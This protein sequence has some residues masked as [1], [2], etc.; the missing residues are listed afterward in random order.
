MKVT[1]E[2]QKRL[3]KAAEE[4]G[5]KKT[6]FVKAAV[7]AALKDPDFLNPIGDLLFERFRKVLAETISPK[8]ILE[9]V[10]AKSS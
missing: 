9:A 1:P 8:A 4:L 2:W 10:E 3:E 7:E 5:I 6:V